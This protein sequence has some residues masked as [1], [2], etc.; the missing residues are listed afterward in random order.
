M[1]DFKLVLFFTGIL[2]A[3]LGTSCSSGTSVSGTEDEQALVSVNGNTLYR[4][5]L[6]DIIP[7][8]LDEADS[9]SAAEAYIQ[10]WVNDELMYEKAQQNVSD[11]ERIEELVK[12][13]R[14]SLTVFTYQEQLL[15]EQFAKSAS[16]NVL[17]TYYDEH[18]DKF[19]LESNIIKG[20]FL[21]IP[22]NS[23]LLD[24][25]RKWYKSTSQ[26]SLEGIEK[27]AVQNAVIYDYFYDK[28]VNFDDVMS[29]IPYTVNN[30]EQFLK[31]NSN[32]EVNDSTYVYLL[33]IKEYGLIGS[34]AP[35]EYAKP[36][37]REVLMNQ[38]RATYLKEFKDDLY[39]KAIKDN[40]INYYYKKDS[41]N[42]ESK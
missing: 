20:L 34:V 17:K 6:K 23:P 22:V 12:N 13:Y 8:G 42:T 1:S 28:W 11:K 15:K 33:N 41:K 14:Q 35:F 21:K 16:N 2:I 3:I 19:K 18:S 26:A 39:Q 31:T 27:N 40:K 10:L 38:N 25:F 32:L 36:Q 37:V 5:D 30:S 7:S 4:S 24:N 29:K 9:A